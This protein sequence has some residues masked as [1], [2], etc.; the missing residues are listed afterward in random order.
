MA[1]ASAGRTLSCTGRFIL[2]LGV[3]HAPMV[4]NFRGQHFGKP[5]TAM[6]TYVDAMDAGLALVG[7]DEQQPAPRM[8]AALGPRM[9]ALAAE[10]SMGALTYLVTPEHTAFARDILGPDVALAVEQAVVVDPRTWQERADWH[11]GVYSS[12]PNYQNSLL[13]FGFTTA[14]FDGGGS[15]RLKEAIVVRGVDA[16]RARVDEHFQA[17]ADHVCLQVLGADLFAAPVAE[18]AELA[19]AVIPEDN[20]PKATN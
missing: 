13:R 17:G 16:I 1:A 11:L 18:W 2:G 15:Q 3:S 20:L 5:V 7:P 8:L 19:P 9:L 12:L 6:R 4:E 10:R 14:D